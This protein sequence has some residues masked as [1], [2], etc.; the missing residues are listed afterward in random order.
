MKSNRSGTWQVAGERKIVPRVTCHG[1]TL[2][3]LLVV[4]AI[5]GILA[6]LLL[7]AL[8][9][10][11]QRAKAIQCL[12]NLREIMQTTKMYLNDHSGVMIP[13]WVE[14]GAPGWDSWNYDAASFVIQNPDLLWWPDRFRLEGYIQAPTLFNCPALIQPAIGNHGGSVNTNNT[15]GIGMNY[16]EFGWIVPKNGSG[17]SFPVYA[18]SYENQVVSASHAIVFADAGAISNPDETDADD[19]REIPATGC[20]YFRVPSDGQGY[21]NGDARSVPR[22]GGQVN[23]TF[24]DGHA[25][26][27]RNSAIGYDLPRTNAANLWSRNYNGTPP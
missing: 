18:T 2:L 26:S 14:Q 23:A 13:E 25:L 21:P 19:W 17:F 8:S 4:I 22:H 27:L 6:A 7:P 9:A 11:K 10:A 15:L 1:F 20:A 16:P 5:I 24:F 3:E 12:S